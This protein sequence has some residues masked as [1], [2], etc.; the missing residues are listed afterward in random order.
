MHS[1]ILYH[2]LLVCIIKSKEKVN[3]LKFCHRFLGCNLRVLPVH[4]TSDVVK[5][6]LVIAEVSFVGCL[7]VFWCFSDGYFNPFIYLIWEN[8]Q[9]LI[10]HALCSC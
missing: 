3:N 2:V 5:G 4:N 6:M 1:A 10:K 7:Y 8:V 9:R